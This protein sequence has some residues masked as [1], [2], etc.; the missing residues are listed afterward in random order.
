MELGTW[1]GA[2]HLHQQV[3]RNQSC[4][5]VQS[6]AFGEHLFGSQQVVQAQV[7]HTALEVYE[8]ILVI[9]LTERL[10]NQ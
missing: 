2:S 8:G 5:S 7:S 4:S 1:C 9:I 10:F 6:D 3:L